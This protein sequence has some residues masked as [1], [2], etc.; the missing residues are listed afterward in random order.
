MSNDLMNRNDETMARIIATRREQIERR[1][2][3]DL[4]RMAENYIDIGRCLNIVKDEGLVPHGQWITWIQEHAQM[5]ERNAQRVMRA[6]RE[7]ESGSPLARLD[8]SKV[9][10]LLAIPAEERE[11]FAAEVGAE[12]LSVRQLQ[13]A[14]KAR[15]EAMREV[16]R[17]KE[18]AE[19]EAE[20]MAALASGMKSKLEYMEG[21]AASLEITAANAQSAADERARKEIDR[22]R[23][24][25]DDTEEELKRRAKAESDA[26]AELLRLRTQV[27]RGAAMEGGERLTADELAAATR[28]FIGQVAVLPHMGKE[29]AACGQK[30]RD[31]YLA[32][33]NMIADWCERARA[34][35]NTFEGEVLSCE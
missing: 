32:N 21:R 8:F 12:S 13:A 27:A 26:K 35:L 20:K 31:A 19:R 25:L 22:L 18:R 30:T 7:I 2:H 1:L 34:A 3:D 6:A 29:L 11:A 9:M 15:E 23:G 17:E 10:A 24:E 16:M 14:V 4:D 5:S 28:A 33:V